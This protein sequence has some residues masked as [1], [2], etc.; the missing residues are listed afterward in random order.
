M[1]ASESQPSSSEIRSELT[2]PAPKASRLPEPSFR[3]SLHIRHPS[4][5]PEDISRELELEADES[6]AAGQPRRSPSGTAL[7][8]VYC[9]TYWAAALEPHPWFA[10][11]G[12]WSPASPPRAPKRIA[13]RRSEAL[14]AAVRSAPPE[15]WSQLFTAGAR[16]GAQNLGFMLS[17]ICGWLCLR[18]GE[19]LRRI[20]A[21]GGSLTLRVTVSPR[22][23]QGFRILP[24]M[25]QWSSEL[26]MTLEFEYLEV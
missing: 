3:L 5:G 7:E 4:I 9:E 13:I 11:A 22:A 15:E 16:A 26:G 14:R 8:S 25:S 6:F 24:Q 23:L 2:M 19:F 20:A 12:G 10:T 18:H 1:T 21:E 17:A